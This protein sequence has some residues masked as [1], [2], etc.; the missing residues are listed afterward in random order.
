MRCDANISLRP[1][2]QEAFGTKAELK[3]LNSFSNVR[4]GL[5]FEQT[6]QEKELL[7]GKELY[8][9]TR[10]YDDSTRETILMR[11]K[12]GQD[13]YRQF[14]DPDILP[15]VI[16]DETVQ[17]LKDS[18]PEMPEERRNRYVE[19]FKIPAYDAGVLTA[20]VEMSDFF[21]ATVE[22]GADA[23]QA[24]NWLMGDISAYLN[25]EQVEIDETNLTPKGLAEMILLIKDQTISSKIAKRVFNELTKEVVTDVR[26][27]VEEKGW[28]QLSDPSQLL[29]IINEV[30]DANEQSVADFKDGKDR[31]KGFLIG[32]VMQATR[33]QANP[34]MVNKIL[35]EELNKR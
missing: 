21:D 23:N 30:L 32:Q 6:R 27:L 25:K 13:D 2:G 31:A 19:E 24:S 22:A 15:F 9:E 5:L 34:G 33:G 35:N 10:R 3:N 18:L 20:T 16:S 7:A 12:M 8:Q 17:K 14:P 29:P 1:F 26:A 11:V 4:R 28:A